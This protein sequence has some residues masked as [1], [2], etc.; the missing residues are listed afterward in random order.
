M[1]FVAYGG[2]ACPSSGSQSSE[3]L[4]SKPT[5]RCCHLSDKDDLKVDIARFLLTLF[6][7]PS[8]YSL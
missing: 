5:V 3:D 7:L 2:R 6:C 1:G 8:Q 4:R